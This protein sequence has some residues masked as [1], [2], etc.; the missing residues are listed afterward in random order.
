MRLFLVSSILFVSLPAFASSHPGMIQVP[1]GEFEMGCGE[2]CPMDDAKPVHKVRLKSFWIDQTP[3]TN[4]AFAK[5]VAATKYKTTAEKTPLAKDYPGVPK[6]K[7][8]AGSAV[9]TPQN[10]GLTNPYAWWTFVDGASWRHIEGPKSKDSSVA[11]PNYPVVHVAYEDALAYC[12]WAQKD[13][14]TEAQ[15]EF[16]ARGGMARKKFSWGDE[17]K[18]GGKWM[19]NIW[20]GKFPKKNA[21]EDGFETL[22]PVDAF[23]KNGYGLHDMGGNV[24]QWT[25]D[26]YR[27]DTYAKRATAKVTLDPAGP[28]DSID[29]SEPGSQK[30]VQRGGS[31]LCSDQY[32][33]RYLVG[34]RGKG[35]PDSTS[36]NLG[37]RCVR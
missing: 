36:S 2:E 30:R 25:K 5:F 11:L 31:F 23:P 37:F 33:V 27:P 1:A 35:T 14:P 10:V 21:K 28:A 22:S 18:P 3:V 9:F 6:E 12:K 7:L 26:W 4:S 24:W 16:A 32:C 17:L 20:Q 15:F 19:A 34:S 13:L 29:P 8:R